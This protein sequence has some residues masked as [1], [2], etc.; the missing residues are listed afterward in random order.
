MDTTVGP[1]IR[2]TGLEL[3]PEGIEIGYVR[4]PQDVRKNGLVWQHRVF[5]P[6]GSDYEDEI[7]TFVDAMRALLLDALDDEDRAEPVDPD[8]EDEDEEVDDDE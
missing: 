6:S 8:D 7:E 4:F 1:D 3:H 2:I 5:V